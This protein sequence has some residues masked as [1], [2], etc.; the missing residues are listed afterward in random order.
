MTWEE[1]LKIVPGDMLVWTGGPYRGDR[2]LVLDV[3]HEK[4]VVHDRLYIELKIWDT[5]AGR[6]E[7]CTWGV[8][9]E[10]LMVQL[11]SYCRRV[12]G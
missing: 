7:S 5:R 6:I 10:D 1:A 9:R 3:H 8:G 11:L 2:D 12:Q 4:S